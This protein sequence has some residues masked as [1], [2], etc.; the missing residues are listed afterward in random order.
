[1]DSKGLDRSARPLADLIL[2]IQ[3][4]CRSLLAGR[5][6]PLSASKR[7]NFSKSATGTVAESPSPF[8]AFFEVR[9]M[10]PPNGSHTNSSGSADDLFARSVGD[11][12]A[13]ASAE[14]PAVPSSSPGNSSERDNPSPAPNFS[15]TGPNPPPEPDS[16][17]DVR[18]AH[19]W[20]KAEH[21]RLQEYTRGIFARIHQEQQAALAKYVQ[22]EQALALRT[23]E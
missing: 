16:G 17:L 2:K 9:G 15:Y 13:Q 10:S 23:Q 18:V 19:E 4:I 1:I 6:R 11:G 5:R 7:G 12:S 3:R 20:L 14:P 8:A 21:K 22:S